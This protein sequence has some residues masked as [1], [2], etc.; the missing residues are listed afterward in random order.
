MCGSDTQSTSPRSDRLV[1]HVTLTLT[2]PA[3]RKSLVST[4]AL[5]LLQRTPAWSRT[6]W[7]SCR[8]S[9]RACLLRPAAAR[10]DLSRDDPA[11]LVRHGF[12]APVPA[13]IPK[14]DLRGLHATP[15]ACDR[16]HDWRSLR[17]IRSSPSG[18]LMQR[19]ARPS[20]RHRV[21]VRRAT[22]SS[23][24][25]WATVSSS[26][27]WIT[28]L[29]GAELPSAT[30]PTADR[31]LRLVRR[32]WAGVDAAPSTPRGAQHGPVG[33]LGESAAGTE[34]PGSPWAASHIGRQ[35]QCPAAP[36]RVAGRDRRSRARAGRRPSDRH[37][38]PRMS[39]AVPRISA[40]AGFSW[41]LLATHR[42]SSSRCSGPPTP[43]NPGVE[44]LCG[45][46]WV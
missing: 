18:S 11:N 7:A 24:R 37:A 10:T 45:G 28:V 34:V 41:H 1:V 31:S 14:P 44:A 17:Q 9:V 16:S 12:S 19:G 5:K 23:S 43:G 29:P 42:T 21:N 13:R 38:V 25:T 3:A 15:S 46:C 39:R 33:Q 22:A 35:R 20:A 6:S 27:R 26:S 36:A 30:P 40:S 4:S 32:R 2:C 8:A